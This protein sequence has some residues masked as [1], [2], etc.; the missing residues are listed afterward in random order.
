MAKNTA[1]LSRGPVGPP[2]VLPAANSTTALDVSTMPQAEMRALLAQLTD[3]LAAANGD[4]P[5]E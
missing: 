2:I 3:A 5:A 1:A 4:Q